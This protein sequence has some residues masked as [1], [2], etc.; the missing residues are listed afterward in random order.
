MVGVDGQARLDVVH[1]PRNCSAE[2][3]VRAVVTALV[4]KLWDLVAIVHRL[5]PLAR[6]EHLVPGLHDPRRQ[7][8]VSLCESAEGRLRTQEQR[9]REAQS[10]HL[11][12]SL[13]IRLGSEALLDF[14]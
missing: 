13:V 1:C 2:L 3:R 6:R 5:R 10:Q 11:D 9:V 12:Q 14:V 4:F 8:S 7:C